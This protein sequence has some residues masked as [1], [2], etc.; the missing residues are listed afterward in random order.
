MYC[1]RGPWL[2]PTYV[3]GPQI[4]PHVIYMYCEIPVLYVFAFTAAA[5]AAAAAAVAAVVERRPEKE[6]RGSER[7]AGGVLCVFP[8]EFTT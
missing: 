3:G 5:A 2:F 6:V 8:P 4:G 7:T 1:W